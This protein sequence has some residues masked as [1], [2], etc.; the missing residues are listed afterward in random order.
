MC[1]RC[2]H[3]ANTRSLH[4]TF[5]GQYSP[6]GSLNCT[7]SCPEGPGS[8]IVETMGMVLIVRVLQ[9]HTMALGQSVWSVPQVRPDAS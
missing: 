4:A 7:M 8:D 5:A 9:G 1:Q 6:P 3:A 2:A